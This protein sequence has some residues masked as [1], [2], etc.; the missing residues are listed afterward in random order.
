MHCQWTSGRLLGTLASLRCCKKFRS[1]DFSATS[2]SSRV[3][4]YAHAQ[5]R[6]SSLATA[7]RFRHTKSDI[8]TVLQPRL[9]SHAKSSVGT[10]NIPWTQALKCQ[11]RYHTGEA[12]TFLGF[13]LRPH[14][15]GFILKRTKPMLAVAMSTWLAA[16]GGLERRAEAENKKRRQLTAGGLEVRTK[17]QTKT[18]R[19]T[20]ARTHTHTHGLFWILKRIHDLLSLVWPFSSHNFIMTK[21]NRSLSWIFYT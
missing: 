10:T 7:F 17:W 13:R 9:A 3:S 1:C 6:I 5:L 4:V 14:Q 21:S 2:H 20:R 16:L 12:P 18:P 19:L 15:A 11:Q 8:S